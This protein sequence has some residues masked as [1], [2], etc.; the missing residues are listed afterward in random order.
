MNTAASYTRDEEFLFHKL[1]FELVKKC[2]NF[3]LKFNVSL[4]WIHMADADLGTPFS[5][6]C[7]KKMSKTIVCL[8]L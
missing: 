4:Q 3:V 8:I 6:F 7:S 1:M 5:Y 2:Q